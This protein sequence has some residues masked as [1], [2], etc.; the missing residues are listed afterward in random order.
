MRVTTTVLASQ[1]TQRT[2]LVFR[3]Q[4]HRRDLL[5]HGDQLRASLFRRQGGDSVL[6]LE[7][8]IFDVVEF[9]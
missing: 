2:V 8:T 5:V 6:V 4:Q 3:V 7:Q 1:A 9:L